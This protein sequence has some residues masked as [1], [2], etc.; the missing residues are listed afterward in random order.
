MIQKQT[1]DFFLP[2]KQRGLPADSMPFQNQARTAKMSNSI[3]KDTKNEYCEVA[4][5]QCA[6]LDIFMQA[7]GI[8][9]A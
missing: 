8:A 7:P 9:P 4:T 3:P 5:S 2:S 1:N 6:Q